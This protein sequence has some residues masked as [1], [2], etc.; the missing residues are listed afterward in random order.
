MSPGDVRIV[1]EPCHL[2]WR[3]DRK[4]RT[5]HTTSPPAALFGFLR[6]DGLSLNRATGMR[7]TAFPARAGQGVREA[8]DGYVPR[9]VFPDAK[10]TRRRGERP[11]LSRVVLV[12][13]RAVSDLIGKGSFFLITVVAAHR[14]SREAFGLFALA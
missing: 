1:Q 9:K 10:G 5:L 8:A 4:A 2:R 14:L 6:S 11:V 7:S 13:Y 3:S 12:G